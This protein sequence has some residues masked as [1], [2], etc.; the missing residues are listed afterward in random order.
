M[1]VM[2]ELVGRDKNHPSVV[3][4]SLANEAMT[5]LKVAENYFKYVELITLSLYPSLTVIEGGVYLHCICDSMQ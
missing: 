3:M 5:K 1:A 2:R 4:W